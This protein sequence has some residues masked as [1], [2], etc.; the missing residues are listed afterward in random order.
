MLANLL[1]PS[2]YIPHGHCFLWQKPLVALH[3]ISDVLTAL[4]YFSIPAMLLY[5]LKDRGSTAMAGIVRLFSAFI[6]FCGVGHLLDVVTLWEPI[7]WISGWERAATAI[8]S[9]YTAG[10]LVVELPRFLALKSPEELEAL[11]ETLVQEVSDRKRAE[12]ALAQ[13]N[14]E[15]EDRVATR[16]QAL[17]QINAT[18]ATE[19][20]KRESV[21]KTLQAQ[22]TRL[23][24][25]QWSLGE[26]VGSEVLYRGDLTQ[27][28]QKINSVA[29]QTLG[30][31]R[32]SI[33][34]YNPEQTALIC[35]ASYATSADRCDQG[36]SLALHDHPIYFEALNR[37]S[38]LVAHNAQADC[39]LQELVES[40]LKPSHVT[41]LLD[42]AIHFQG[43]LVGVLCLEQVGEPRFWVVEEQNFAR[44][45]STAISM[46][47]AAQERARQQETLQ[48]AKEMADA[49][50][51]AK[52]DFLANMSHELRTPLNA[53]LGF[54]Q[55]MSRDRSLSP[56]HRQPVDIINRSGQHL[57]D[58]I[59]NVLEMS[60]IESGRVSF[61]PEE[62]DLGEILEGIESLFQARAIEQG[63]SLHCKLQCQL[64]CHEECRGEGNLRL[65]VVA[66]RQKMQQVLINLLGN[67]LK[68]TTEG[69]V[70]L[71][72]QIR[73]RD[74][75]KTSSLPPLETVLTEAALDLA[76]DQSRTAAVLQLV[77]EDTG[78]G[79]EPEALETLFEA[80]TQT[81][82]G[83]RQSE[84]TGLGL[85]ISQRLVEV[86]GGQIQV[87]SE[88][89]QGTRFQVDLPVVVIQRQVSCSVAPTGE[90]IGLRPEQPQIRIL[91]VEDRLENRL[92]LRQ[93]LTRVG[94]EEI[95]EAYNGSEAV[96]Q[97]EIWQ[98]HLIFMDIRMPVM[99]GYAATREIRSRIEAQQIAGKTVENSV[100]I[101]LTASA[102]EQDRQ[103][104]LDQ[105]CDDFMSKPFQESELLGKIA[106]HL[107]VEYR[108]GLSNGTANA[109]TLE[110]VTAQD[111]QVMPL[112]WL[113]KVQEAAI[114]GND[115]QLLDLIEQIPP[116]SQALALT[117]K[118]WAYDFHFEPLITL[119]EEITQTDPTPTDPTPTETTPTETT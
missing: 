77:V 44:Y 71:T 9:C 82:T 112:D 10:T 91:I 113:F 14:Q 101:A 35:Q 32:V 3:V 8:V 43:Q 109:P 39:R 106:Q 20:E 97:W 28:F 19:I 6:I 95:R 74:P 2:P 40:Y 27:A 117:L 107:G 15:L 105:G 48:Q 50:N 86:M 70:S 93:V 18:L 1:F 72:A 88:V 59:N 83:R 46:A 41:A 99:D 57:I 45:L 103:A 111:L 110:T 78:E 17:S 55:L 21:Q 51:R 16:T 38:M 30:V 63:L 60:R 64:A 69:H 58:L 94:F 104:T 100:I 56:E 80:F 84:G 119:I 87:S 5:F 49:A 54:T 98:P 92:L 13:M 65:W 25:Q 85:S 53:I 42:V 102:F 108:Y 7:Y 66:D 52:S 37:E 62:F 67:A 33:W 47:M 115:T 11:N 116:D 61:E 23:N 79:I 29:A 31:S 73:T 90:V 118:K 4:A 68:F 96:L 75:D 89:G 34:L 36:T 81:T 22:T 26:L 114:Q 24:R 12:E 76:P